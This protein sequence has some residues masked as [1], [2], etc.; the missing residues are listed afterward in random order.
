MA[1]IYFKDFKE[2]VEIG[3][4]ILKGNQACSILGVAVEVRFSI[5]GCERFRFRRGYSS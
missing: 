5:L 4:V 3:V 2:I 1:F